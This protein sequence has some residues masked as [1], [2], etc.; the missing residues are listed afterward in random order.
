MTN[1]NLPPWL[2]ELLTV[3]VTKLPL[4]QRRTAAERDTVKDDDLERRDARKRARTAR[5]YDRKRKR[6]D[7]KVEKR[8]RQ[9]EARR[10][11]RLHVARDRRLRRMKKPRP[12]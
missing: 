11:I 7:W 12:E 9:L 6:I 10:N 3:L 5:R 2:A 8:R 4:L 1:K